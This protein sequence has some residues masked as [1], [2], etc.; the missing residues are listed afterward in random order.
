[1]NNIFLYLYPIEEFYD[2]EFLYENETFKILNETITNRY[3]NNNYKI[4]FILY[5]N[6]KISKKINSFDEE[7]IYTDFTLEQTQNNEEVIYQAS[8]QILSKIICADNLVIGG[9]H[10]H[11]CVKKLGEAAVN[12]GINTLVDLDLTEIF[13]SIHKEYEYFDS[14][15]Y[16]S[17][18][19]K[20][21]FINKY[22]QGNKTLDEKIFDRTYKS[23]VYGFNKSNTKTK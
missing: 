18:K 20:K 6:S 7:I 4:F 19:F 5:K 13:C 14:Y 1:M 15:S 16:E 2:A 3:R 9:F 12:N 10:A 11:D 21:Y 8:E 17:K 22:T 23:V